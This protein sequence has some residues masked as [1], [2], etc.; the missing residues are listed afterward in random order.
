MDYGVERI[1]T[2]Y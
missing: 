2:T 1:K